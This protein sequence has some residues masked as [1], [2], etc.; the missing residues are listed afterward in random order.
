MKCKKCGISLRVIETIHESDAIYRKRYCNNC[1]KAIYTV[2]KQVINT[3]FEK[4]FA[5]RAQEKNKKEKLN[6]KKERNM[7]WN[8]G[9]SDH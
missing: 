1:E 9:K 3:D 4:A 7:L 8:F 5:R 2:E 6:L